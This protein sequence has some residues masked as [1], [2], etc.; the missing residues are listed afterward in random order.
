MLQIKCHGCAEIF[1]EN[2]HKPQILF[3]C[4]HSVCSECLKKLKKCPE[5]NS[6]ISE[7]NSNWTILEL[8]R[9]EYLDFS[10]RLCFEQFDTSKHNPHVLFNCSHTFCIDCINSPLFP[11]QDN[12]KKCPNCNRLAKKSQTNH[13]LLE[14]CIGTYYEAKKSLQSSIDE[15]KESLLTQLKSIKQKKTNHSTETIKDVRNKV[16][17]RTDELVKLINLNKKKLQDQ[18]KQIEIKVKDI[19]NGICVLKKEDL[20]IEEYTT[21]VDNFNKGQL[22]KP[23]NQELTYGKYSIIKQSLDKKELTENIRY[24]LKKQKYLES[25]LKLMNSQFDVEYTFVPNEKSLDINSK[26]IGIISRR[27]DSSPNNVSSKN[28]IQS[29]INPEM[30]VSIKPEMANNKLSNNIEVLRELL[31]NLIGDTEDIVTKIKGQQEECIKKNKLRMDSIKK[32]IQEYADK[33]VSKV[34]GIQ[35]ELLNYAKQIET[36]YQNSL[37]EMFTD[38]EK[39]IKKQIVHFKAV[40]KNIDFDE[41]EKYE[42][43]ALELKNDL[44]AKIKRFDIQNKNFEYFFF[45]NDS[46][47][48]LTTQFVGKIDRNVTNVSVTEE[49]KAKKY[50]ETKDDYIYESSIR[51]NPKYYDDMDEFMRQG[52]IFEYQNRLSEANEFFTKSL[53]INPNDPNC[54][55]KKGKNL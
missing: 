54:W 23:K 14:I 50:T 40:V 24:F 18:I 5:C 39:I 42:K 17:T 26:F 2:T 51:R 8:I 31:K 34:Y 43:K 32:S 49:I 41:I 21:T 47:L 9:S 12:L 38:E 20:T 48:Q 19:L 45:Q 33:L 55:F 52:M 16:S 11:Q 25:K 53:E 15:S 30:P 46:S 35:K 10:C 29:D 37:N 6:E 22:V 4:S 28:E 7:T 13:K 3:D 1:D 36:D 27:N 44:T